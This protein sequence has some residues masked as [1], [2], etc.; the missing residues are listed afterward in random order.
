[1]RL[2]V[3]IP[4]RNAATTLGETLA[5]LQ[6]QTLSSW[7][8]IV[9]DDGSTDRT[10]EIAREI[11]AA[12]PR[13]RVASGPGSGPGAARNAGIALAQA[14][15]LLFLD[16]DDLIDPQYMERMAG[17]LAPG[18]LDGALC[19]WTWLTPDGRRGAARLPETGAEA[20]DLFAHLACYCAFAI[21]SCV[22]RR[23]LVEEVGGFDP[24]L[25]TCEDWDLWQRLARAGARFSQVSEVL[26][27]YRMRPGS[28]SL[29]PRRLM[30]D[31]LRVIERGHS[32][33]PR[34]PRPDPAHAAG[35]DPREVPTARLLFS[36]WAAGLALGRGEDAR[37]LLASLAGDR[38][39]GLD[40]H[41]VARSL[42]Q[43]A[44]LPTGRTSEEWREL[45]P[46]TEPRLGD[47][48]NAL[49]ELSG[50][51]HLAVLARREMERLAVEQAGEGRPFTLGSTRA[52]RIELTAPIQ[53]V[54]GPAATTE[55]L[56]ALA[57][58]EGEEIGGIEL[59]VIGGNVPA[60]LLADALAARFA[61]TL[62]DRFLARQGR[63]PLSWERFL[64]E[65]WGR[66]GWPMARF[67]DPNDPEGARERAPRLAPRGPQIEIEASGEVPEVHLSGPAD[68]L[69]R[70]GGTLIGR[71]RL[72]RTEGTLGAHEL[73]AFLTGV[74][75]FELCRAAVREAVLGQPLDAPGSLRERLAAAARRRAESGP[76]KYPG[77]VLARHPRA[78]LGS[79]A[80]RRALL[81]AEALPEIL[82]L[83]A[84]TGQAAT[85][86]DEGP[87]LPWVVY[88]PELFGE[89]AAPGPE[90]GSGTAAPPSPLYGRSHFEALFAAGADPWRYT[91]P[92]E[93]TKYGQTLSLVPEGPIGQALELAC[94][95]GHFTV[96]LAPRVGHLV[97][98]DISRIAL[99][100]A[101]RR[102]EGLAN[103]DFRLLD[104]TREALPGGLDLIICSEVLYYVSGLPELRGVAARLARALAPDGHLLTAHACLVADEPDRPGFD[105]DHPFGA[106]VIGETLAGAG[107]RLVR[108]IRT[109]LYRIQLFRR[110]AVASPRIEEAE[111]GPLRPEVARH[112]LWN[113]GRPRR[114]ETPA[115]IRT[116]RLPI[117]LYHRIAS[118][119]AAATARYRVTPEAFE[120]QLRYLRDSGYFTP[121]LGAW[122]RALESKEPLPGRAVLI[123]FDDGYRDF[124]EHAGR[125]LKEYGFSALVFLVADSVGGTNRWDE[126]YGE[127]LPLL[128]WEE[129]RRLRAAGIDFG[130]HTA[131]HRPLTALSAA[132]AVREMARSRAV[133][134]R[135]LGAPVEVIAYP[136][137]ATDA[138]VEHL[139]A[140][141]GYTCGL[142]CRP[143]RSGFDDPP[144]ALPRLEVRGDA[145]FAD[146]VALL[147]RE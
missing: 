119:G 117:L 135:E 4:A 45:W 89:P 146:F 1:M 53:D 73:R 44:L 147:E 83:A 122:L 32:S 141:C 109:P 125:L 8:A 98:A 81:P 112:V 48:L 131:T 18:D 2:S 39:P 9:V 120:E 22:V 77:V 127:S 40:P 21:H 60:A 74:S 104:L 33:D 49:E 69:L 56:H 35:R 24:S 85:R 57:T 42:F 62:L 118:E 140:A 10:S 130:S 52:V 27:L 103:V 61:W 115:D 144:L 37:P 7:D 114:S 88:A 41:A 137:G 36:C 71:V 58:L 124:A 132:E 110:G 138:V 101:A 92:Y 107:L 31:C 95:E 97:A 76:S 105:W 87:P 126:A 86:P 82:D 106:Q 11:A 54:E 90:G 78:H 93:E 28:A 64:Q 46:E 113:G 96:R 111:P 26:A 142:T 66:P 123:T 20:G 63:G 17:A 108:E 50:A 14:D 16:A 51:R 75:G 79:P 128:G 3:V 91:N 65:I 5:S 143:A 6:A 84:A 38:D 67:Y 145:S 100:R 23:T 30:E 43:S 13:V 94:A 15:W 12:D 72:L 34:V 129:I 99:E 139:A 80:S 19:G 134:V 70:V 116:W 29:D 121:R 25:L 47:F 68:A 59:P 102:C 55:R 136:H 133:L